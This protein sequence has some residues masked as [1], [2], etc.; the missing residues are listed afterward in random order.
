MSVYRKIDA[1]FGLCLT[2]NVFS[3]A[4]FM[5]GAPADFSPHEAMDGRHDDTQSDNILFFTVRRQF[6]IAVI[7]GAVTAQRSDASTVRDGTWAWPFDMGA[8]PDWLQRSRTAELR[9]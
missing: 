3:P 6:I 4:A 5:S 8:C 7:S 9:P 2:A 1:R